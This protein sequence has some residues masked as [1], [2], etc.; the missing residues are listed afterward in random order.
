MANYYHYYPADSLLCE[1]SEGEHEASRRLKT[2]FLLEFDGLR[3]QASDKI[4]VMGATNR[5]QVGKRLLILTQEDWE[6]LGKNVRSYFL[7][8][9]WIKEGL[10]ADPIVRFL[11]WDA[12]F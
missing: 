2:E 4:L 6:H 10:A 12:F 9:N 8:T 5:P 3:G 11:R 7:W 1:R